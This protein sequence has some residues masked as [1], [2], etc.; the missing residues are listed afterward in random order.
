MRRFSVQHFCVGIWL[1]GPIPRQSLRADLW[2]DFEKEI[3]SNVCRVYPY[4]HTEV[5]MHLRIGF[6]FLGRLGRVAGI[7]TYVHAYVHAHTQGRLGKGILCC[8]STYD[9]VFVFFVYLFLFNDMI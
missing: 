8:V 3:D 6:L 1:W 7:P 9:D 2:P 4:V 5:G